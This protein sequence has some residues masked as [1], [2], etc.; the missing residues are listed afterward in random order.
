MVYLGLLG[1]LFVLGIVFLVLGAKT[2]RWPDVLAGVFVLLTALAFVFMM[3]LSL[4]TRRAWVKQYEELSTRNTT[5]KAESRRLLWGDG[6]ESGN[7]NLTNL[8]STLS[9]VLLDRGRVWR[10]SI[11]AVG[12]NDTFNI[13]IPGADKDNPHQISPRFILYLFRENDVAVERDAPEGINLPTNYIGEFEVVAVS[14]TGVQVRPI[15]YSPGLRAV[16]EANPGGFMQ[17]FSDFYIV[18]DG[19]NFEWSLYETLPIDDHTVFTDPD[20]EP[21]LSEA[22][23]PAFGPPDAVAINA[24]VDIATVNYSSQTISPELN[25]AL[26]EIYL[27]DG[28]RADPATDPPQQIYT[29]VRLIKDYTEKVDTDVVAG[30]TANIQFFDAQGRTQ[31]DFLRSEEGAGATKGDVTVPKDSVILLPKAQATQLIEA[32][33]GEPIEDIYVRPLNDFSTAL[34]SVHDRLLE[35]RI[36]L[37]AT[38][39]N[40]DLI[41]AANQ[42]LAKMLQDKQEERTKLEAD[43]K[44]MTYERQ[45]MEGLLGQ[46][47]AQLT[48]LKTNIR[49]T[50]ARC[51]SLEQQI[52]IAQ[53]YIGENVERAVQ[54]AVATP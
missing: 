19:K 54:E 38:Q 49:E 10:D 46:V 17:V 23:A 28:R 26:K 22:G 20:T 3:S 5:L 48:A 43:V 2:W 36:K 30:G 52:E 40:L 29:K 53:R 27:Q 16:Q 51:L 50:L 7:E 15:L 11:P 8:S 12:P 24:A 31:V 32:G 35:L 18:K 1:L 21:D 6:N 13:T 9:R 37:R 41:T 33:V 25:Q 39:R 44:K 34:R 45:Q 14:D 47:D 4:K 42:A